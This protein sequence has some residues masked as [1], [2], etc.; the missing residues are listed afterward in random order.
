MASPIRRIVQLILD[1]ASAKKVGEDA[2]QALSPVGEALER[3]KGLATSLA[4]AFAAAF[5]IRALKRF[6]EESVRQAAESE[7]AWAQLG[8]TIDAVGGNF[9]AL[10]E[11]LRATGEAFQ[12]ATIHDNEA[13]A[14]SLQRLIVLTGDISASMNNM[15]LVADVAAQFF[16]GDLAPAV[17]LVSKVMNGN[18]MLL[19]RMG[20]HVKTAQQGLEVLAE[21][22]FGA[23]AR[24][25]QTFSGQLKQLNNLWQDFQKEVGFALI[26]G[27]QGA[28]VLDTLKGIV[29]TLTTFVHNNRD[30]I[31]R[32]V[33]TGLKFAVDTVD[34]LVRSLLGLG[35]LF[36]GAWMVGFGHF[37]GAWSRLAEAMLAVVRA[38]TLLPRFLGEAFG[39]GNRPSVILDQIQQMIDKVQEW[40]A[41]VRTVGMDT[42]RDGLRRF[43]TPIFT[44]PGATPPGRLPGGRPQLS[45]N[46]EDEAAR[47]RNMNRAQ[48]IID[49]QRED[50]LAWFERERRA[51]DGRLAHTQMINEEIIRGA[52]A[53]SEA[54]VAMQEEISTTAAVASEA[55]SILASAIQGASLK[56][57]ASQRAKANALEAAEWGIKAFTDAINPFTAWRVPL[58]LAAAAKHT[59][60]ALAWRALAGSVGGGSSAPAAGV[61][62]GSGAG[63]PLSSQASS[64]AQSRG[65]EVTIVLDGPGF[66]ALNPRVQR[67]VAGA[68]QEARE[69]YGENTRIR[70]RRGGTR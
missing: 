19:S 15:G 21:R 59:G 22:S 55:G 67:V 51:Q 46:T 61:G 36:T 63:R 33:T 27:G 68:Q 38:A 66:D 40:A 42:V 2:K 56:D 58:D 29:R 47:L 14:T 34:A 43:A 17:E 20:I 9:A 39:L 54:W 60:M 1:K 13:Y 10:E 6:G 3:L 53:E 48:A 30:A 45:G 32:W 24:E 4:A 44:A 37:V 18:T 28:S 64:S 52:E 49:A 11:Q 12:D 5:G 50:S 62:G 8:S 69:R 23:A 31:S 16:G 70:L 41:A 26:A 25:T 65:T 35:D 7:K 57:I